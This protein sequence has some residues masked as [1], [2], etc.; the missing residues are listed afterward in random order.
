V[1]TSYTLTDTDVDRALTPANG[2]IVNLTLTRGGPFETPSW[3]PGFGKFGR[4]KSGYFTLAGA[5]DPR[6]IF[7]FSSQTSGG[8]ALSSGSARQLILD[9][10]LAYLG[11]LIVVAVPR[12][13]EWRIDL[14]DVPMSNRE[15]PA[16]PFAALERRL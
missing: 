13:S 3:D 14:S 8:I 10:S 9:A 6:L 16:N 2:F 11:E 5:L 7:N 12:G 1:I 4:F 15:T